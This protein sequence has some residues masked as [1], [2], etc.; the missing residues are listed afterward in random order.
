M[1]DARVCIEPSTEALARFVAEELADGQQFAAL[2]CA[3]LGHQ[4]IAAGDQTF[5]WIG[6]VGDLGEVAL[7]E[8]RELQG[9]ALKQLP[10]LR[11]SFPDSSIRSWWTG[12]GRPA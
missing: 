10:D 11:T 8:Q 6:R 1:P 2:A 4:R 9:A 7:I 12:T 5:G 3:L